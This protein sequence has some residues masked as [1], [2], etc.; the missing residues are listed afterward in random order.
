VSSFKN[1]WASIADFVAATKSADACKLKALRMNLQ[2]T[3][4]Q[5]DQYTPYKEQVQH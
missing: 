3:H 5:T 4:A 1:D 2:P